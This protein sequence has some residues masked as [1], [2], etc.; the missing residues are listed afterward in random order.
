[1]KADVSAVTGMLGYG[2]ASTQPTLRTIF[3]VILPSFLYPPLMPTTAPR[4]ASSPRPRSTRGLLRPWVRPGNLK[5][6]LGRRLAAG[7]TPAQAARG[8]DLPE[9]EV[10]ALVADPDFA[11]L[12]D[13]CRALDATPED[14]ARQNLVALARFLLTDAIVEGDLR[15][16]IFVL[17]EEER[18]RDPARTLADGVLAAHRR[19]AAPAPAPAPPS[20]PAAPRRPRPAADPIDRFAW[21]AATYFR[22]EIRREFAVLHGAAPAEPSSSATSVVAAAPPAAVPAPSPSST[23]RPGRRPRNRRERR[24]S[25]ALRRPVAGVP[26]PP[27]PR[28]GRAASPPAP[29]CSPRAAGPPPP[30]TG[31]PP[32]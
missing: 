3:L 28:A 5:L 24:R 4:P 12:V 8:L 2:P 1:M 25:A 7:L 31:P 21:R 9:A 11:A 16:V 13:E 30:G 19:A 10:A 26:S 6:R 23:T 29:A 20:A 22:R 32:P 17:R 18:G 27:P 15:A 14:E